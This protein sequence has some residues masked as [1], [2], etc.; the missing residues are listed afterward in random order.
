MAEIKTT[1]SMMYPLEAPNGWFLRVMHH[2][3]ERGGAYHYVP[4]QN[5]S[6]AWHVEF[7][8]TTISHNK[9]NVAFGRGHS[10]ERAWAAAKKVA[11][12]AGE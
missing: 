3:H 9:T 1:S 7:R 11:E 5:G 10:M 4:V 2:E 8:R 6:G 12:S